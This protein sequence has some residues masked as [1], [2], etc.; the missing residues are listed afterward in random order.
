MAAT[1]LRLISLTLRCR[2]IIDTKNLVIK[3]TQLILNLDFKTPTL[4]RT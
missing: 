2:I 3:T 1:T 4:L